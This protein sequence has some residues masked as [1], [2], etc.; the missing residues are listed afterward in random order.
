MTHQEPKGWADA[1]SSACLLQRTGR[2]WSSEEWDATFPRHLSLCFSI[3]IEIIYRT[4]W[5]TQ[6]SWRWL[7]GQTITC[8]RTWSGAAVGSVIL[9]LMQIPPPFT[10]MVRDLNLIL[11]SRVQPLC[12]LFLVSSCTSDQFLPLL[13][14]RNMPV[15]VYQCVHRFA[16]HV[17][18]E[19]T[20]T[21][22]SKRGRVLHAPSCPLVMSFIFPTLLSFFSSPLI[23]KPCIRNDSSYMILQE[24]DFPS[25]QSM[26]QSCN[27]TEVKCP[28][29]WIIHVTHLVAYRSNS[30]GSCAS[31]SPSYF[32]MSLSWLMTYVYGCVS[33]TEMGLIFTLWQKE[34]SGI[35]YSC[36]SSISHSG[37]TWRDVRQSKRR[38]ILFQ[39]KHSCTGRLSVS[40]SVSHWDLK[41]GERDRVSCCGDRFSLV[42]AIKNLSLSAA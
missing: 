18:D 35:L 42:K 7:S 1:V 16:V 17:V 2:T 22:G 32:C 4:F 6:K 10:L 14:A 36:S 38:C 39:C 5:F 30:A 9:F 12:P 3:R 23:M 27:T 15:C 31:L 26:Y 20:R 33:A 21:T 28:A 13:F 37:W 40:E 19:R 34:W 24:G 8:L 11:A 25:P 29:T 41:E